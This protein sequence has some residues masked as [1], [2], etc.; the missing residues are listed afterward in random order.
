MDL[1]DEK[2]DEV[3]YNVR[4]C[5]V[6]NLRADLQEEIDDLQAELK[7][8]KQEIEDLTGPKGLD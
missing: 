2:H 5:P 6:C 4:L 7:D 3:C 8:A 1:C